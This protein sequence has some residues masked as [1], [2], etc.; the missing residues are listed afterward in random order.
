MFDLNFIKLEKS[1]SLDPFT[2]YSK[3]NYILR[4]LFLFICK[5]LCETL[6][7]INDIYFLLPFIC[8]VAVFFV[9]LVFLV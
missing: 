5:N 6:K 1:S 9:S 8:G 4:D 3:K 7:L 2:H